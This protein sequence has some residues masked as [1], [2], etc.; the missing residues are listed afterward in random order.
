VVVHTHGYRIDP[1]SHPHR[2]RFQPAHLTR[3]P[4]A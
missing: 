3:P 1:D 4:P 2:R